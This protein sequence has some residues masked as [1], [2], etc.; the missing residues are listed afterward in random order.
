MWYFNNAYTYIYFNY[1]T[2][3]RWEVNVILLYGIRENDDF[4]VDI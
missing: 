1:K 3:Y 4:V 2:E